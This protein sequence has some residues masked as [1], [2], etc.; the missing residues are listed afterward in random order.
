MCCH[1]HLSMLIWLLCV[2]SLNETSVSTSRR[3]VLS[4]SSILNND[5]YSS[6]VSW[7]WVSMTAM[8]TSE[9]GILCIS[10]NICFI[11]YFIHAALYCYPTEQNHEWT[12]H[13]HDNIDYNNLP[14]C[15]LKKDKEH[16]GYIMLMVYIYCVH[17]ESHTVHVLT[18]FIAGF[19]LCEQ[20]LLALAKD[21][22][23]A[24]E[25]P[26]GK[27]WCWSWLPEKKNDVTLF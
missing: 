17:S 4:T 8:H 26:L 20:K 12:T 9:C 5:V 13:C 22:N 21:A 27:H 3:W 11:L 18:F 7:P 19:A 24:W 23:K 14:P 6:R 10:V 15:R 16:I 2:R 1:R 25:V